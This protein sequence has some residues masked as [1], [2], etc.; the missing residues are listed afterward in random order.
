MQEPLSFDTYYH[1]YNRGNNREN[2]FRE[3][4]N[5]RYFLQLYAKYI[6]P[7]ADTFAYCLLPNHFHLLVRIKTY[8]AC[9]Q[10]CQSLK[11][12]HSYKDTYPSRVFSKLFGT[13]TKAINKRYQRT[14]ALFEKPFHRIPVETDHYFITLVTYIHQNPQKHGLINDFK[15]WPY[16]SYQ[17]MLS[18]QATRLKRETVLDWFAGVELLQQHHQ[19][20]ARQRNIQTLIPDDF[21]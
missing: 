9:E 15:D 20:P 10:E 21:D 4:E 5:Y 17:A 16:S 12:W 13:Y 11:D 19:T 14:G 18:S 2:L 3:A 1:I 7:I 6:V 8:E